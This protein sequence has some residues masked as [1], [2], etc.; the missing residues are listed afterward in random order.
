MPGPR[1]DESM[2]PAKPGRTLSARGERFGLVVASAAFAAVVVLAQ[3]YT[4]TK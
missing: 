1:F 4:M 3:I 2:T